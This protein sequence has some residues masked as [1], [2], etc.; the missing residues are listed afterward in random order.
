MINV[1]S[2]LNITQSLVRIL[3]R[4]VAHQGHC[5]VVGLA[6]DHQEGEAAGRTVNGRS[7]G[8]VIIRT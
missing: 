2:T 5:L 6:V 1:F 8:L 3:A 4:Q 7:T